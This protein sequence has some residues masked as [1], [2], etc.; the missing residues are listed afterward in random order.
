MT[1]ARALISL[2]EC[3]FSDTKQSNSFGRSSSDIAGAVYIEQVQMDEF[4]MMEQEAAA[5]CVGDQEQHRQ[6][7]AG[8]RDLPNAGA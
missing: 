5:K 2:S 4:W 8:S 3:R 6:L 1:R 7:L